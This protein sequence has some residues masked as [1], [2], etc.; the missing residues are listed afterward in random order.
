M[1]GSN[2]LVAGL[3]CLLGCAWAEIALREAAYVCVCG[4]KHSGTYQL[5]CATGLSVARGARC[6][7]ATL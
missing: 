1:Q 7:N 6:D 2:W 3:S 5:L 4:M